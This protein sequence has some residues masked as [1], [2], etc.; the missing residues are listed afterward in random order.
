[1]ASDPGLLDTL[2]VDYFVDAL[3]DYDTR[4]RLRELRHKDINEAETHAVRLEV[5][6]QA[7]KQ[8]GKS[9]HVVNTDSTQS[10]DTPVQHTT[11]QKP[12]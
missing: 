8:M 5:H 10:T 4:L 3:P 11:T 7:D 6:K 12:N 2:A 1:M 9:V